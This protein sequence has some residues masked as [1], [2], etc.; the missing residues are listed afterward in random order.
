MGLLP[1]PPT[2]VEDV[3]EYYDVWGSIL[4][5]ALLI[6]PVRLFAKLIQKFASSNILLTITSVSTFIK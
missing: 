4:N 6:N 3:V 2:G 5:A 1:T